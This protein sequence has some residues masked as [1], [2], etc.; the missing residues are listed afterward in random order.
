MPQPVH[1]KRLMLSRRREV[2]E[3]DGKLGAGTGKGI[4]GTVQCAMCHTDR[5]GR[6]MGPRRVAGVTRAICVQ[7]CKHSSARTRPARCRSCVQMGWLLRRGCD[8]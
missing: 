3:C 6:E 5:G 1:S 8:P 2:E 7:R 4:G